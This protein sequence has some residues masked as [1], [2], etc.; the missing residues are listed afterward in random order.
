[1][2]VART[3]GWTVNTST[4]TLSWPGVHDAAALLPD[5]TLGALVYFG[6]GYLE[7]QAAARTVNDS[8]RKAWL[9]AK[10][11]DEPGFKA[12]DVPT[13]GVVPASDS[14]EYRAELRKAH[15]ALW[16]KLVKGYEVGVREGGADPQAEEEDKLA[17]MWLQGLATQFTHGGKPWFTLPAKRKVARD[18]DPYDGP[19]YATFGEALAAFRVSTSLATGKLVGRTAD[20]KAWP[21]KLRSGVTVAEAIV[22]EATRRVAERAE[23]KSSVSLGGDGE[24]VAF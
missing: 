5:L 19:K 17:R 15:E 14:D 12:S 24:D 23:A 8:F 11:Q 3:N 20:G 1:M 21:W 13:K 9:E 7:S 2:Q 10:R 6:L 4:G 18:E 16:D 22:A